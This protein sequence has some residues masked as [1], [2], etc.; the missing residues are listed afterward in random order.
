M[1]VGIPKR[2]AGEVTAEIRAVRRA[3][4]A[5]RRHPR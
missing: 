2:P 4:R 3:R 5:G 1:V